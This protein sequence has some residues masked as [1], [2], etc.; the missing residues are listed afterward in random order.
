MHCIA[1]SL[2]YNPYKPH[3]SKSSSSSV[4]SIG[5]SGAIQR[6]SSA[7]AAAVPPPVGTDSTADAVDALRRQ[8]DQLAASVL[9]ACPDGND[10]ADSSPGEKYFTQVIS[11][12][13]MTINVLVHPAVFLHCR[14]M[15]VLIC[16]FRHSSNKMLPRRLIRHPKATH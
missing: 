4:V 8:L 9:A 5:S 10:T 11:A 1:Q 12:I 14:L 16:C 7:G 13:R 6:S 15:S 3:M 2:G